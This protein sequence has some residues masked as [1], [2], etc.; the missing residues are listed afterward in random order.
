[1]LAIAALLPAP[2]LAGGIAGDDAS[3]SSPGGA[4]WWTPARIATAKPLPPLQ[5]GPAH[6]SSAPTPRVEATSF[7]SLAVPDPGVFPN[8][9][10]GKLYGTL[11]GIGR[12][13][14]SATVLDSASGRVLLTAGHCLREPNGP[15]AKRLSFIPGYGAGAR[16]FGTW[17][18]SRAYVPRQWARGNINYD[19]GT[20]RL[21]NRAGDGAT[22]E[23]AVGGR[24]L[25]VNQPPQ[26][27][28]TAVGYPYNKGAGETMWSCAS[29]FAGRDPRPVGRGEPP[30]GISCDMTQGAS[31]GGWMSPAGAV[32]SVSSFFYVDYPDVL[33]GPYLGGKAAALVRKADRG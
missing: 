13:A 33:F 32:V 19:F 29:G 8:A 14:C 6:A 9:A 28:Y 18:W 25:A 2:A 21:R 15:W 23:E 12:F 24:P 3:A 7:I 11:P 10:N 1:M 20:I 30:I 22:A 26:D 4:A 31:G 27:G 17:S 5:R 16:P